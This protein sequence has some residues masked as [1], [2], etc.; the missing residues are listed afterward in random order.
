MRVNSPFAELNNRLYMDSKVLAW[1]TSSIPGKGHN[2]SGQASISWPFPGM[3]ARPPWNPYRAF[4][5]W[6]VTELMSGSAR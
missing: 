3:L 2:H 6:D 4:F 1:L 5:I